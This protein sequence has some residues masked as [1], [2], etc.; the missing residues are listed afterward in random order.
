MKSLK[1]QDE[2]Q[3]Q[4]ISHRQVWLALDP[5]KKVRSRKDEL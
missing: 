3:A 5:P 4:A 1:R 2:S